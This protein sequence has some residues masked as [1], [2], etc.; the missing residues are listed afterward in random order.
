MSYRLWFRLDDVLPLA[1][2]AMACTTHRLTTA[3]AL[4]L[5]PLRPALTWTGSPMM[6][7]LVS[8]GTPAWYG[9]RG[10][11]HA[12][13]AHTWRHPATNRYGTA[14][15]NGYDIAYLPLDMATGEST[16]IDLLRKARHTDQHWITVDIDPADRHLIAPGR[17][18][19][20]THRDQHVPADATWVHA[21][22]TSTAVAGQEYP[23]LVADGYTTD[24][25]CEVPRFDRATAEL[26]IAD[27]NAVHANP[28]RNSDPM[29]GEYP[30]L[31]W[32]G[33]VLL[34]LEESDNVNGNT[35]REVDQAHPDPQGRYA[36]GAYGW[37]WQRATADPKP[38]R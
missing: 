6:D 22:V 10:A 17:V 33:D 11:D 5:A 7:V 15:V 37:P 36:I 28:D 25:G 3:Q 38:G 2:H 9:E 31:R 1:E 21:T 8:N 16:V 4:A 35:Y 32:A 27:L 13:E 12:A 26:M 20:A 30:H 29:P 14:L 34:L 18:A 19:A 24:A 23:A